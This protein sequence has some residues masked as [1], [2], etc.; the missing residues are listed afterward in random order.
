MRF[1]P[2][3]HVVLLFL[4][5]LWGL[6]GLAVLTPTAALAH[7]LD[8]T[9]TLEGTQ[10]SG[11]ASFGASPAAAVTLTLQDANAVPLRTITGD[12]QG[13]FRLDLTDLDPATAPLPWTLAATTA[14]GHRTTMMIETFDT[15]R[16]DATVVH[17]DHHHHHGLPAGAQALIGLAV[18]GGLAFAARWYLR[19]RKDK[20]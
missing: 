7:G 4:V 10:L 14:D 13:Q 6:F 1:S 8:L 16:L 11:Q 3:S 15:A 2:R 12:A 20:A 18:I 5:G 9:G 17:S 19:G